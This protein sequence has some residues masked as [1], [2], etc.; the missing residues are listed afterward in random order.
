MKSFETLP[1]PELVANQIDRA[2]RE[3]SLLRKLYRLC[4]EATEFRRDTES[5]TAS[6]SDDPKNE[7]GERE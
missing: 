1:T 5:S 4:V 6:H 2:R 3:R 7:G